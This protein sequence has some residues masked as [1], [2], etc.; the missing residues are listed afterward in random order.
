ML[1]SAVSVILAVA[2]ASFLYTA[3]RLAFCPNLAPA[4]FTYGEQ[5]IASLMVPKSRPAASPR[6]TVNV[7]YVNPTTE[8]VGAVNATVEEKVKDS[9]SV[10]VTGPTC[11]CTTTPSLPSPMPMEPT[12][13]TV[14]PE[15]PELALDPWVAR[16]I[17]GVVVTMA[18]AIV[19]V[20]CRTKSAIRRA[21]TPQVRDGSCS[22]RHG[23]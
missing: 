19:V 13:P 6:T 9:A 3:P 23:C 16:F 18:C 17:L 8:N 5:V 15:T 4:E 7:T 2:S 12:V 1:R 21:R 11:H 20:F 10:P 14:D 22:V